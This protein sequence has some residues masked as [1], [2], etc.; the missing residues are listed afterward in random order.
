MF[1]KGFV[2]R[3]ILKCSFLRIK[4]SAF[5]T[6]I[7]LHFACKRSHAMI[8]WIYF[9]FYCQIPKNIPVELKWPLLPLCLCLYILEQFYLLTNHLEEWRWCLCKLKEGPNKPMLSVPY[10]PKHPL[11]LWDPDI[12]F[13]ILGF[14]LFLKFLSIKW[15]DLSISCSER[16]RILLNFYFKD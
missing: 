6:S 16:I 9:C 1:A 12:I 13:L 15:N 5:A 3:N 4:W 8:Y 14:I 7:V 10:M 2:N 11:Y